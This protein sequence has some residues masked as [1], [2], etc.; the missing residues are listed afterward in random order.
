MRTRTIG[1]ALPIYSERQV[2]LAAQISNERLE[3]RGRADAL[4]Q[5]RCVRACVRACVPAPLTHSPPE[6]GVCV[7][8][9]VCAGLRA[10]VRV[11]VNV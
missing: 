9:C 8:A 10:C 3:P 1:L 11:C 4:R 7:C 6:P 5:T 2:E